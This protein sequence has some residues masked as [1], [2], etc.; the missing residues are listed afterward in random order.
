MAPQVSACV[1]FQL[2]GP[3]R[4]SDGRARKTPVAIDNE[5]GEQRQDARRRQVRQLRSVEMQLGMPQEAYLEPVSGVF[6]DD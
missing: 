6:G 5:E 2:V 3:K 4:G 1:L